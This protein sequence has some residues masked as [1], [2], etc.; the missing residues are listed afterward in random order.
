[1]VNVSVHIKCYNP[2]WIATRSIPNRLGVFVVSIQ[3][4]ETDLPDGVL[5][6]RVYIVCPSCFKALIRLARRIQLNSVSASMGV[7]RTP[8]FNAVSIWSDWLMLPPR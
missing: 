1:M 2:P 5:T 3:Y 6:V 7:K 4:S 8:L